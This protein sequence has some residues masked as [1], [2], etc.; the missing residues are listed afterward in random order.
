MAASFEKDLTGSR[1]E[2]IEKLKGC[3]EALRGEIKEHHGVIGHIKASI[4]SAQQTTMLS[5]TKDVID[6]KSEE[7]SVC[8]VCFAAIVFNVDEEIMEELV[9]KLVY[10]A[11]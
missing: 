7:G 5:L 1:E 4:S 3:M 9:D 11:L 8:R 2:I 10:D 6:E